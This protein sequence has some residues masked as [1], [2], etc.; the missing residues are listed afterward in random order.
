MIN[1]FCFQAKEKMATGENVKSY[2]SDTEETH[3]P[4]MVLEIQIEIKQ[5]YLVKG[6]WAGGRKGFI[7]LVY[8]FGG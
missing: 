7:L 6:R 8:W 5:F 4:K 2:R 3:S 1:S